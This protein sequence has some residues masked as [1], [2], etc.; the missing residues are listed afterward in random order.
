MW[1]IQNYNIVIYHNKPYHHPCNYEM[2]ILNSDFEVW[3][4]WKPVLSNKLKT[5]AVYGVWGASR[6]LFSLTKKIDLLRILLFSQGWIWK[7]S[8]R[9]WSGQWRGAPSSCS[10]SWTF[11]QHA[12]CDGEKHVACLLTFSVKH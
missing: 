1:S 4:I 3:V 2:F 11:A 8:R 12:T 6:C 7:W 10:K 9:A 5:E